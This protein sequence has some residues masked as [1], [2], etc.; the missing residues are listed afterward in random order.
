M[1][2]RTFARP[3]DTTAFDTHLLRRF[4]TYFRTQEVISSELLACAFTL[5]Y[6]V[7]CLER[8]FEE[9]ERFADRLERD[10]FDRHSVHGLIF[11]KR[12]D[13]AIGTARLILPQHLA[14]GLPIQVQLRKCDIDT[15]NYFPIETTAEVSRFAISRAFRRANSDEFNNGRAEGAHLGP[16]TEYNSNLPCLGL[17]QIVIQM[18]HARGITHLAAMM[19]PTLLRMLAAMG[20][21]FTPIGPRISHH[22]IRQPAFCHISTMLETLFRARPQYWGVV[23]DG[24]SVMSFPRKIG[25]TASVPVGSVPESSVNHDIGCPQARG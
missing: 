11:H 3:S 5:R 24:A 16:E 7:Y 20:V 1:F 22:G 8:K 25:A 9:P 23:T 10:E 13:E 14:I 15:A 12:S 2:E 18:S 21:Y 6:R 17:I 4:E 19:E